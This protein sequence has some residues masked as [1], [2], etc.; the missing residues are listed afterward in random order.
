MKNLELLKR[1]TIHPEIFNGK[2]VI[3]GQRIAVEHILGMI[4][5]GATNDE[6]LEG[7]PFLEEEDIQACQLYAYKLVAHERHEPP[8]AI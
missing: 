4:A 8:I 2:P 1:I 7:Y 5:S 3:R 6:I